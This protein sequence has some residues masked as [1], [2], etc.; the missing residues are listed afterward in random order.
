MINF[1][2]LN[3]EEFT[4]EVQTAE[5]PPEEA[6]EAPDVPPLNEEGSVE[7]IYQKKT[8]GSLLL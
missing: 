3:S 8:P 1:T 5:E 7:D 6:Q 2:P 4:E